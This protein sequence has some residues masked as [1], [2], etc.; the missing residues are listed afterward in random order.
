MIV[1]SA[2]REEDSSCASV[3]LFLGER[4]LSRG[5]LWQ[6]WREESPSRATNFG[7]VMGLQ[8]LGKVLVAN[9]GEIACRVIRTARR[10]GLRSVAVYSEPDAASQHGAG[11]RGGVRGPGAV[12]PVVPENRRDPRR[13]APHGGAGGASRLR[14]PLGECAVCRRGRR[15]G[16]HAHRAAGVGD[17]GD[18]LEGRGEA[19]DG[20]GGRAAAAG[21]PRRGPVGRAGSA[22]SRRRAGWRRGSSCC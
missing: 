21:V 20:G 15:R 14:L 22:T 19:A 5:T 12:G 13:G 6:P 3:N 17:A 11:G 1:K 18:G 8:D 10:L 4:L 9:R 7:E 16:A 2:H